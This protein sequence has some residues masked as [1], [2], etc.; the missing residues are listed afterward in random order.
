MGY[1]VDAWS[2]NT[3]LKQKK[4]WK[5]SRVEEEQDFHLMMLPVTK[6]I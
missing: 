1:N 3:K 6:I 5:I 2:R 4:N